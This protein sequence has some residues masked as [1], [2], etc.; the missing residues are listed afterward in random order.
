[1][2]MKKTVLIFRKQ[3]LAYSETFIAAQADFL[4]TMQAV[5]VGYK[6]NHSAF[7][8]ISKLKYCIQSEHS[9]IP[10][11]TRLRASLGFGLN[12]TCLKYL[13]QEN[14]LLIHAHFGTNAVAAM[15]IARQLNIPLLVTFHGYD[16]TRNN[17]DT[18][19]LKA[20]KNLFQE[21][22]VI[23]AISK[24]IKKKLIEKGCPENKIIQHYIGID[25]AYFTGNK[26]ESSTPTIVFIG[27]LTEQKGCS[28]LLKAM[29]QVQQ[30]IPETRLQIIGDG[31]RLETLKTQARSLKNIEFLGVQDKEK[32]REKLLKA[33]VFCTPGI[34]PENGAEE[35]LGMV[36]LEAQALATPA[37]SFATGG[38]AEAIEHKK[39]GL[40]V[41]EK[42]ITALANSLLQLLQNKDL[43]QH[44]GKAG[45]ARIREQFDIHKQCV[46][47]EAIY[48]S[49]I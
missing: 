29:Q 31:N 30:V 22:D 34:V 15:P 4:P 21:A 40:I 38:I 43:R 23:I 18:T 19:Y 12:K 27:R 32:I 17:E 14:P 35:G 25:T 44:Y 16:I 46:S 3:L 9:K 41:P 13:K 48:N 8:L 28:Y 39:T 33:W 45:A 5:F 37:V 36:F 7:H 49:V 2:V 1:M 47:L 24:F 6:K 26:Q 11:I 10:A 20:R 42:D